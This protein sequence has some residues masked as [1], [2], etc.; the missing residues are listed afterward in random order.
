MRIESIRATPVRVPIRNMSP[1]PWVKRTHIERTIVE[2]V[3]EDGLSGIGETRGLWSAA[4][5]NGTFAPLLV[6]QNPFERQ[7]LR[8]MSVGK[9]DHAMPER[10]LEL[11]AFA[12][13]ELALWDLAGKAAG[14]PVFK[15]L[16]GAMRDRPAFC[17]YGY[18]PDPAGGFAEDQVPEAMARQASALIARTGASL[19]EFKIGRH[20]LE[21]DIR[22]VHAVR[23]ALG[24]GPAIAVDA[25]MNFAADQAYRFLQATQDCGLANIEEPTASLI[26]TV[27]LRADFGISVSTHCASL[28]TLAAYPGVDAVVFDL[29]FMGGIEPGMR[30]ACQLA[31]LG[32]DCWL[33]A[34]WELGISFA[35]MCHMAIA[36]REM[37][38]PSQALMA[39]PEDDLVTGPAWDLSD[40]GIQIPDAAGLGVTLDRT[41]LS[42]YRA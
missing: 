19:F 26:E 17:A 39:F 7:R 35:A 21:C 14:Q 11:T 32:K 15:L 3:S 20:S 36:T 38:R 31:A 37:S 4:I 24:P 13:I 30:F 27:R 42:R 8:A 9:F 5:I 18:P 34:A 16:G 22:T 40:G 29:H 33:R 2:I 6:G 10:L 23:E 41:A 1:A 12:G 28:D 25:N